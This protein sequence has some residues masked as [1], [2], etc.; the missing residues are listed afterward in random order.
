MRL[1]LNN[2]TVLSLLCALGMSMT[3]A[4]GTESFEQAKRG[5]FTSL[6]TEYGPLSC[7]DGVAE[8]G[9]TGKTGNSSLRMFGGKDAELKLD[10]KDVPTTEVRLSAWAERWTGQAP[11]EFSITAVGSQGEKE[12][13]DGKNIKTGGFKTKI[14]AR[15]PAGTRSL[16]FKL[17]APENKGLKLDDLFIVP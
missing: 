3:G 1:P 17:T 5:K 15:V 8:I 10:L 9:G 12:I 4:L 11:F 16:V 6:Q 14:E 7:A 2:L 13:Y